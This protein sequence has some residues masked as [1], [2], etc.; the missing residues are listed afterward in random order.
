MKFFITAGETS[1]DVIGS[2]LMAELRN[3]VPQAIFRGIGGAEMQAQGLECITPLEALNL[4]GVTDVVRNYPRLRRLLYDTAKEVQAFAPA[5]LITIDSP[6]FSVRLAK[7]VGSGSDS[8]IKRVQYVCP[9][10]WA[11]RAGRA[12]TFAQE[13]D[14]LLSVLDFDAPW[15]EK[16]GGSVAFVG[17]PAAW[18]V[19]AE[20]AQAGSVQ[21]ARQAL[22][23]PADTVALLFLAGS[24]P[25]EIDHNLPLML[26]AA[27][28]FMQEA[29][30]TGRQVLF[31]TP[32]LPPFAKQLNTALHDAKLSALVLTDQ[33]EK[34]QAFRAADLALAVSG[35]VVLETA[36][37][38][39]PTVMLYA[40]RKTN[41]ALLRPFMSE[42]LRRYG[43]SLPNL[44]AKEKI[45]PEHCHPPI[46]ASRIADDLMQL[47]ANDAL[48]QKMIAKFSA[49]GDGLLL[50][51][52]GRPQ[53]PAARA[54]QEILR[55]VA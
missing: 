37:A 25:A 52:A 45:I 20:L 24:R 8:T 17:H 26:A 53:A 28:D 51:E 23:L 32:T 10:V 29:K 16:H 5:A 7:R 47:L 2:A 12:K 33:A 27:K 34:W 54:A 39:V 21:T 49:L 14:L 48:R 35:T 9:S 22:A 30:R 18:R 4:M 3:A 42:P 13:Y 46:E 43:L 36:L 44:I 55:L 19:Q 15:F 11:W 38:S 40:T 41:Y 31:L 50:K 1:G 6:D